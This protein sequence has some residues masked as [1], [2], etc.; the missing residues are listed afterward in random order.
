MASSVSRDSL[1]AEIARSGVTA[2]VV[3]PGY[4]E[5][6]DML[7]AA[8][9]NVMRA[10]GKSEPESRAILAK[11]SPRGSFITMREIADTVIWLCSDGA[12]AINGQAIAVDAGETRA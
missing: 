6:T 5:G 3:C 12:S 2:N 1:A 7:R 11:G 9:D 10:T 8:T 4:T